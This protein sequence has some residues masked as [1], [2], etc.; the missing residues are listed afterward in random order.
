MTQVAFIFPGQGVQ[1]VGMGKE[2]YDSSPEA[3]AIFDTSDTIING[4]SNIIFNGPQEKL[5]LTAYCQP[6]IFAC[7]IAALKALAAHPKF[8]NISPQ[9]S[10]GLSL[11]EYSALTASGALSF[12]D[13]LK[14]VERRSFF[15]EE[16]TQLKKGAMT[17]VIGFDQDKL[18]EICD[19]VGAE[20]ANFNTPEQ[21][22]ITGEAGKVAAA[23]KAIEEAGAK[24]VIPLDVSGA[25]HSN[26][27]QPAVPKFEEEVQKI[28]FQ[29]ANFPV[30]GNVD[31][32]PASEAQ[33]IKEKLARQITSS[34]Q[35]VAS[36][37]YIASQGITHFIEIGPENILKGLVR[38]INRDLKVH[39]VR[40]PDDLEKLPF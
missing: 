26:L 11:G 38:K 33:E 27:M 12:E 19:Q 40:T 23:S 18:Q 29:N 3:K 10:C 6:G 4:L 31:G 9:Y 8:K 17:A 34:V 13:T 1:A 37:E 25:F 24:R 30:V 28:S 14:L 15:M 22:V 7:S 39:N 35:W 32:K 16:A 20:V 5:T 21:I 2:F 36:V